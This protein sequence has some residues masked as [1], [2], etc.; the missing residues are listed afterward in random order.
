MIDQFILN[1]VHC[2]V[3]IHM[4][5]YSTVISLNAATGTI[6]VEYCNPLLAGASHVS[7]PLLNASSS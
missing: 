4:D 1:I 2:T 6:I 3:V 7:L 5:N